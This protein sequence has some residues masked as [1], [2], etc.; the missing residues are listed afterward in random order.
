MMYDIDILR[1][2]SNNIKPKMGRVLITEPLLNDDVFSRSVVY[3]VDDLNDSHLGFILN[4]KTGAKA[5][6]LIDGF[7][8]TNLDVYIGGPV[9][10]EVVYVI[11]SIK[12]IKKS[13][14]I[15]NGLFLNGDIDQIKD[16]ARKGKANNRNTKIFLGH[17]AWEV[18]QLE[19]EIFN[20]CWLVADSETSI[21][22][23]NDNNL[24]ANSLNLVDSRY[25]IWKNFPL[26]PELN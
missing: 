6:K 21:V 1:I 7:E 13:E 5:S 9:N 10:S 3:L 15:A 12:N 20:N 25:Q 8:H 11:H 19:E 23:K 4:K 17:S 24:W 2:I 22:F 26:S 16:L 14:P 18:G